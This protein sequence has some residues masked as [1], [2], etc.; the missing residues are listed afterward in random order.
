MAK[1]LSAGILL[2]RLRDG[3]P[4]V[5]LVHPGG[6]YWARKDAGAWSI[7]KGE[8]AEGEDA[9][10][11][12][13]R[14]FHEETGAEVSGPYHPLAPITLLSGKRVSAWAVE[15]EL[16]PTALTSNTFSME[17]PPRSGI[18]QTFPEVDSGAWFDLASARSRINPGQRGFLDQLQQ[19]LTRSSAS[20]L[21]NK[22]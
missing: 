15:G 5:F 12:A 21:G 9:L 7:P 13:R 14:E 11:A 18:V 4:Q 10:A 3:A 19:L 22:P 16:D 17:W 20:P 6:P 1:K 2:Y 8:Y